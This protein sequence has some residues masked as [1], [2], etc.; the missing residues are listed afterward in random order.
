MI[1]KTDLRDIATS[2]M[3]FV[4]G[5]KFTGGGELPLGR[6]IVRVSKHMC[7]VI[8]GV[9]HDT[10]NPSERGATIYPANTLE[11]IPVGSRRLA[12][13]DYCYEPKRCVYG[14]WSKS[15]NP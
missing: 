14:Y 5:H 2:H 4:L 12:N 6:L 7:A 15:V 9:I 8:D 11:N 3:A 10:H 1:M 13:G